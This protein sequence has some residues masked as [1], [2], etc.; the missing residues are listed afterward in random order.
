MTVTRGLGW[1]GR[2][3][4]FQVTHRQLCYQE[5]KGEEKQKKNKKTT[6]CISQFSVLPLRDKYGNQ[7]GEFDFRESVINTVS[8]FLQHTSVVVSFWVF[9]GH[10]F[11]P[12]PSLNPPSPPKEQHTCD[13]LNKT[14]F[15]CFSLTLLSSSACLVVCSSLFNC[16]TVWDER[17]FFAFASFSV[18]SSS[19]FKSC[20]SA[21]VLC[22]LLANLFTAFSSSSIVFPCSN[23]LTY[24][25]K[26]I[27]ITMV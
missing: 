5:A 21:D 9:L 11:T 27:S 19:F 3:L 12:A 23:V 2:Q 15:T 13:V 18:I 4:T 25:Q 22:L 17:A 1:E 24:I 20:S 7:K 14:V 8:L 16:C 10:V 26:K 6:R